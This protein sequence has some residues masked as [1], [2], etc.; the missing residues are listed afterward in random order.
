[1]W[2]WERRW[3]GLAAT[4]VSAGLCIGGVGPGSES[5][6]SLAEL[7]ALLGKAVGDLDGRAGVVV[8]GDD[9]GGVE[10]SEAFGEHPSGDARD[11]GG[12]SGEVLGAVEETD[13]DLGCPSP[14]EELERIRLVRSRHW[15]AP[16]PHGT[17]SNHYDVRRCLR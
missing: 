9:A 4:E 8:A 7:V 12:E 3:V 17:K 13:E 1:M 5:E 2:S 14:V 11:V 16:L 10:F 15:T 6:Q